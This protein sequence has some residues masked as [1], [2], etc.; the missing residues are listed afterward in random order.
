M[1]KK[2]LWDGKKWVK[3]AAIIN[4]AAVEIIENKNLKIN[5]NIINTA[6]TLGQEID[7]IKLN[8]INTIHQDILGLRNFVLSKSMMT[9]TGRRYYCEKTFGKKTEAKKADEQITKLYTQIIQ[10]SM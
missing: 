9:K 4:T 5:I 6:P 8:K 10:L 1:S 2:S 3:G 7:F